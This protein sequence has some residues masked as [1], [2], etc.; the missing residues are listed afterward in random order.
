VTI[1]LILSACD[2]VKLRGQ[3]YSRCADVNDFRVDLGLIS[4]EEGRLVYFVL[5][6]P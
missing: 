3:K 1:S 2:K 5:M 6:T 4:I